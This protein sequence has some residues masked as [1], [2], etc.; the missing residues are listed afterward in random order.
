MP[1]CTDANSKSMYRRGL[2]VRRMLTIIDVMAARRLPTSTKEITHLVN[3]A[4][5]EKF[6]Q[7]TIY[8]DL[9]AIQ[10]QGLLDREQANWK[11]RRKRSE[12]QQAA[13]IVLNG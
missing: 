1:V 11:L 13:A 9:F 2:L 3:E 5:G 4:M 10:E 8:R 7:R 6:C 12:S